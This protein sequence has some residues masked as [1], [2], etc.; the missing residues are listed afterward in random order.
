MGE[1]IGAVPQKAVEITK[2]AYNNNMPFA[3]QQSDAELLAAAGALDGKNF[4]VAEY[5]KGLRQALSKEPVWSKT[6]TLSPLV[7]VLTWQ[8]KQKRTEQTNSFQYS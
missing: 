7:R 1:A 4:A 2:I 5:F 3:A 8:Q 6:A